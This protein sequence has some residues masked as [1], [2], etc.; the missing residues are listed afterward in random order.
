M[1]F[2]MLQK[3][4]T[5]EAA[6]VLR[7]RD[8]LEI[9]IKDVEAKKKE[10]LAA[11]DSKIHRTAVGIVKSVLSRGL[12]AQTA[13]YIASWKANSMLESKSEIANKLED[14]LISSEKER[15]RRIQ[16]AIISM[17]LWAWRL[18][19][20]RG[21]QC[22]NIWVTNTRNAHSHALVEMLLKEDLE[23]RSPAHS[24]TSTAAAPEQAT[25]VV[26]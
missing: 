8:S 16:G 10:L 21:H 14:N 1:T 12:L 13:S 7:E 26:L 15:S 19:F 24:P 11:A 20:A 25:T 6:K 9:E 18:L 3:S 2:L 17:K 5:E 4:K 23:S 22:T